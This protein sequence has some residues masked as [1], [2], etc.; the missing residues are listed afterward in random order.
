MQ[1][2]LP[3]AGPSTRASSARAIQIQEA[4]PV[5]SLSLTPLQELTVEAE[6]DHEMIWEQMEL[7]S[8]AVVELLEEMFGGE[9]DG[10]RRDGDDGEEDE[11][12]SSGELEEEDDSGSED[13]DAIYGEDDEDDSEEGENTPFEES[14]YVSKLTTAVPHP[15]ERRTKSKSTAESDSDSDERNSPEPPTDLDPTS[16]L[17]LSTFDAPSSSTAPRG[18]KASGPPSSVDSGFFSLHDFHVQTDEGEFEMAKAM[19]GEVDED[20]EDDGVDLFAA[21]ADSDDEDLDNAGSSLLFS[22][23][24]N[25]SSIRYRYHVRRLF[26]AASSSIRRGETTSKR[27]ERKRDQSETRHS[28]PR[29]SPPLRVHFHHRR[30]RYDERNDAEEET[31]CEIL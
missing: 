10:S 31:Q 2:L 1:S 23:Y 28:R 8:T 7:R 19:R 14:E 3:S 22:S 13:S 11:V 30:R 20:E 16:S 9:R 25:D 4:A 18:R 24:R 29:R 12:E 21:V 26:R 6:M 17:T 15:S 27:E 5:L